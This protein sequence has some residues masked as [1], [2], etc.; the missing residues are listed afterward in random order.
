[1]IQ[2]FREGGKWFMKESQLKMCHISKCWSEWA[3]FVEEE[4]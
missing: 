2:E 1:M 4:D 3:W